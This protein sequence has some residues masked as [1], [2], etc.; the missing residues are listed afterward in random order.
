MSSLT[1]PT[2]S[3]RAD[4]PP[5]S[6]PPPSDEP[7]GVLGALRR[8]LPSVSPQQYVFILL[9]G[10]VLLSLIIVTGAIVRLTG[11][12]LGCPQWPT[13]SAGGVFRA[14]TWQAKIELANRYLTGWIAFIVVAL[15]L[16][17]LLRRPFRADLVKLALFLFIGVLGQAIL[18]GMVVLFGLA[19]AIVM[20]HFLLSIVLVTVAVVLR[21]R[22][23]ENIPTRNIFGRD[24]VPAVD[25]GVV[26]LGRAQLLLALAVV[27]S[28]TVVT[29]SG[30]HGGDVD[31]RRFPFTMEDVSRV[32]S[33]WVWL[34]LAVTLTL[35][36]HA[37]RRT[38]ATRLRKPLTAMLMVVFVQGAIGYA[39]Y[40]LLTPFGN[41]LL[42]E[43]AWIDEAQ[44][45]LVGL[46]IV[47]A[48]ALWFAVLGVWLRLR[49]PS[50]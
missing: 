16:A 26:N 49:T 27:V 33:L 24:R 32:H 9:I 1:H 43:G 18:G 34:L 30:P 4:N 44:T 10:L 22:A 12:G 20:G 6:G 50:R 14:P 25:A 46:H 39:Q 36:W 48:T 13:C 47:G 8:R 35:A 42:N 15:G 11:S 7:G 29:S 5:A 2:V 38:A 31:V 23:R 19:P 28:G 40:L 37:Q 45:V 41:R 3:A 17:S 21:Y